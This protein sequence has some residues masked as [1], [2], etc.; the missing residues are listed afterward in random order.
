[1]GTLA[2]EDENVAEVGVLARAV[3]ADAIVV[4]LTADHAERESIRFREQVRPV[5]VVVSGRPIRIWQ[6]VVNGEVSPIRV[7][8]PTKFG[9]E[10]VEIGTL[11]V[12]RR[13]IL[14][15]TRAK[16]LKCSE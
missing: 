1:M 7:A 13:K 5:I 3:V 11:F 14:R 16:V 6:V 9:R 12:S 10:R 2:M 4:L 15:A 8:Y